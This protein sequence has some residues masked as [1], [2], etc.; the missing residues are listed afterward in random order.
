MFS[1]E[2]KQ[3]GDAREEEQSL[4]HPYV[5]SSFQKERARQEKHMLSWIKAF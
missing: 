4:H 1:L 2:E 3:H 5:A